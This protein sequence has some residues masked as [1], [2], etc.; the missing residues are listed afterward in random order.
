VNAPISD[1]HVL[2]HDLGYGL[3]EGIAFDRLDDVAV[4]A[5]FLGPAP[6]EIVGLRR[7]H[8]DL[9]GRKFRPPP[10]LAYQLEAIHLRHHD[11]ADHAVGLRA[12]SR[13]ERRGWTRR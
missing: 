3:D 5:Q 12:E 1:E 10:Q 2:G 11:V 8:D 4:G 6:V 13:A 7:E 9:Q